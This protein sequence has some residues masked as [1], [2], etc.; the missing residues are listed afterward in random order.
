[1]ISPQVSGCTASL[2]AHVSGNSLG[3]ARRELRC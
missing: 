3:A 2:P 1:M